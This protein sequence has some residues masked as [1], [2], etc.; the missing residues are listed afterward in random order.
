[1]GSSASE[2]CIYEKLSE[3]VE[4][5]RQSGYRYG[6]NEREIEKFIT[7]VLE[8]NEPRRERAQ[9]PLLR[10]TFVLAV[11][12][13]LVVLLIFTYPQSGATDSK[14]AL[15]L[16]LEV[17]SPLSHTRLLTLPIV[18]K[19]NL[20]RFGRWWASSGSCPCA[21][22]SGVTLFRDQSRVSAV[23]LSNTQPLLIQ[24]GVSL[25]DR[26]LVSDDQNPANYTLLWSMLSRPRESVLRWLF[27]GADA[28]PLLEDTG[29][30]LQRC[31]M[32]SQTKASVSISHANIKTR[33]QVLGWLVVAEGCPDIRLLP[34]SRC[35]PHCKSFSLSLE[36]GDMVF[37]DSLYWTMELVP[38]R[39]QSLICDGSLL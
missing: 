8:S 3:S 23:E 29:T 38:S 13:V 33:V 16:T 24:A 25:S 14:N 2:P 12:V 26:V 20:Q 31:W 30:T 1:M 6:M 27:P 7:Q 35:Q 37:A 10:A 9:F 28:C 15:N 19:Y 21:D 17:S 5:L 34:V 18:S 39:E 32:N 11:G 36:P 22:V 4:I